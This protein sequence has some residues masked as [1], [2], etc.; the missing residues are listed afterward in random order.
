MSLFFCS[1]V[2]FWCSRYINPYKS[3]MCLVSLLGAYHQR[4]HLQTLGHQVLFCHRSHLEFHTLHQP[5]RQSLHLQQKAFPDIIN[6]AAELKLKILITVNLTKKGKRL[7]KVKTTIN[8]EKSW[9]IKFLECNL[10]CNCSLPIM[11]KINNQ[12]ISIE[13]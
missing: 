5:V 10:N 13:G 8:Y 12:H 4:Q 9:I 1:Y 7:T 6:L 2:N 3:T 11:H